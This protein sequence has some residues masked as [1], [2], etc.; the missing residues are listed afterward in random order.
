MGKLIPIINPAEI[1]KLFT[2]FTCGAEVQPIRF[3]RHHVD[4]LHR[5]VSGARWKLP[6]IAAKKQLTM[7]GAS[8][9]STFRI[10]L[11]RLDFDV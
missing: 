5:S 3:A 8:E 11:C 1:V 10:A 4:L 7:C 2:N 6:F 9:E